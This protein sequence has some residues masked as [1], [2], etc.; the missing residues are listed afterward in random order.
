MT[1]DAVELSY[2]ETRLPLNK[3]NQKT[4]LKKNITKQT[5][6]K[7]EEPLLQT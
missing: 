3:N 5:K 4:K 6:N 7:K 1:L 2:H